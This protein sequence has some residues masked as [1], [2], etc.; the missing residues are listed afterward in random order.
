MLLT[1]WL[2]ANLPFYLARV[3]APLRELGM[4]LDTSES[5][6]FSIHR[7]DETDGAQHV[8]RDFNDIAE[9]EVGPGP[10]G[11]GGWHLAIGRLG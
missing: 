2:G 5:A 7:T 11:R 10:T 6:L 3:L 8:A 9:N 4:Q 1:N